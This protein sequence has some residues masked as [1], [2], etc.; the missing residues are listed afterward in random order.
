MFEKYVDLNTVQELR[1][2]SLVYFGCGAIAK[3]NEIAAT[4]STRGITRVLIV[5]S[6]HAYQ[7]SGAWEPVLAAL[8]RSGITYVHYDQVR[9]N[10]TTDGIDSATKLG[11]DNSVQAVIGIGGGSPIDTAK[12]AA[13]LLEYPGETGES[14]F[15]WKFT[16]QKALPIVAINLT[17][18]TGTEGN[19]VAVAS[20][21]H[22]NYKPAIAYD[23][24][25]PTWS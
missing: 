9:P 14:L 15:E 5:T 21:A 24:I 19:R 6:G 20:V 23:C 22:R 11:R 3:M 25:Y 1:M 10:P 17:H 16:P 4:M 18:G 8:T 2:R 13:I 12:S 7:K